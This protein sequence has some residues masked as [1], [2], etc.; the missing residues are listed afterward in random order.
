M[1]LLSI[2]LSFCMMSFSQEMFFSRVV[3]NNQKIGFPIYYK[4]HGTDDSVN[5]LIKPLFAPRHKFHY[6]MVENAFIHDDTLIV[7]LGSREEIIEKNENYSLSMQRYICT[8][9]YYTIKIIT[10]GLTN[11]IFKIVVGDKYI[12]IPR[13]RNCGGKRIRN[14]KE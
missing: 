8:P 6:C 11:S 12:T 3:C 9:K 4:E 5:V 7:E 1:V 13:Q 10:N 14:A 2:M